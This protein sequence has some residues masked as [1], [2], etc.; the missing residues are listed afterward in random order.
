ME[1]GVDELK[2]LNGKFIICIHDKNKNETIIIN[3]RY[4]HFTCYYCFENSMYT[5]CNEPNTLLN[6]ILNPKLDEISVKQIFN[7]GYMLDD[8]TLISNIRK[9]DPASIIK[10]KKGNVV[11]EK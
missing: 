5:F 9:I 11:F 1:F 7:Y 4:G 10:I 8:R 2:K 3:D 6:Y